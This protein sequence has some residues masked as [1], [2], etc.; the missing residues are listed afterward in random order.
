MNNIAV[1]FFGMMLL[2]MAVWVFMYIRRLGFVHA[3]GIDPQELVTPENI[4][5]L[6]PESVNAASNNLKNLVELPVLFYGLCL[7][8][9]QSTLI[10]GGYL[11]MAY[12]FLFLRIIH[13]VIHCTY[14]RVAHR[15]GVYLLSCFLLWAMIVRA[16][17]T[18]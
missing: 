6:M 4:T 16:A 10:D 12:G 3:Q 9:H 2:T 13:S 5:R 8:L 15:F 17:F 7:Y 18:V 14:N 11:W 1:P